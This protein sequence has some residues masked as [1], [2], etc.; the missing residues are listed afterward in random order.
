MRWLCAVIVGWAAIAQA[1][2]TRVALVIG[3]NEGAATSKPLRYA[4]QDAKRFVR[5][6]R[7]LG[8]FEDGDVTLLLAPTADT[9]C[10]AMVRLED[11]VAAYRRAGHKTLLLVYYAGHAD[12]A[13]LE[14]GRTRLPMQSIRRLMEKADADVRL[15]FVDA[16][17]SGTLTGARGGHR[18]PSFDLDVGEAFESSGYAILTSSSRS[19]L[20]QESARVRAGWFSHYLMSALRGAA[21]TSGDGRIT[22]SEAYAYAY[23]KTVARTSARLGGGQHPTFAARLEGRGGVVLTRPKGASRLMIS[24]ARGRILVVDEDRETLVAETTARPDSTAAVALPKGHYRV[25]LVDG[26][27]VHR[28]AVVVRRG[29]VQLVANT[30][31]RVELEKDIA[32]GGIFEPDPTLLTVSLGALGRRVPLTGGDLAFGADLMVSVEPHP[33]VIA[34][35]RLSGA[36]ADDAVTD[37]R[38][39]ELSILPGVGWSPRMGPVTLRLEAL[40]GY[41][42]L[43][44]AD[45]ATPAFAWTGLFG[46]DVD[47]GPIVWR[48]EGGGGGRVL[49]IDG[50]TT[51][52]GD[53]QVRLG[54]GARWS[55]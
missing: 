40:A 6:L 42:H 52:R 11:R 55:L 33:T 16:C 25:Y 5:V 47:T 51:H 48:L 18:G 13:F 34:T 10:A 27:R 20:S 1:D 49:E 3:A 39:T 44:Q 9:V 38:Y 21:D 7:D 46:V 30:F 23:A 29:D 54:L 36:T 32:R 22:L 26:P 43:L 31:E 53:W 37:D 2:T 4:E 14:L 41:E 50:E 24:G 28:A 45:R 12:G 8:G 15:A 35:L 19:E 17:H